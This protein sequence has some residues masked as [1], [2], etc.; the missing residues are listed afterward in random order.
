MT[1]NFQ[2]SML[3]TVDCYENVI[4]P[5]LKSLLKSRYE[6]YSVEAENSKIAK[7]LD[8]YGGCDF[9]LFNRRTLSI[10]GVASR[11]QIA[12]KSF[13]TF[14]I[15]LQRET[16]TVTEFEKRKKA[17]KTDSIYPKYTFQAYVSQD[18]KLLSMA[19][20][21]TVDLYK[22][23]EN[24]R[25]NVKHTGESQIGQASFIACNWLDI[26]EAGFVIGVFYP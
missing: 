26:R 20:M 15:R 8:I 3:K 21:R 12:E 19:I 17:I 16:G 13:D 23:V 14:T 4:L 25:Q 10:E 5:T 24:T 2:Q 22:F 7:L 11:I 6:I 18:M 1:G 9:L